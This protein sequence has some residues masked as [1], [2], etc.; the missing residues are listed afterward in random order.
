CKILDDVLSK[1][2]SSLRLGTSYKGDKLPL[3]TLTPETTLFLVLNPETLS[4]NLPS[5]T[6][7][8]TIS[9]TLLVFLSLVLHR[10]VL[11][12]R[13]DALLER[14]D[15]LLERLDD[16][17][18]SSPLPYKPTRPADGLLVLPPSPYN[19]ATPAEYALPELLPPVVLR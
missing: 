13:L 18:E 5:S 6:L 2:E 17:V 19:P 7:L 14:L 4:L 12:T 8:I 1:T 10:D 3:S 11:L 15:T 16:L 9:L